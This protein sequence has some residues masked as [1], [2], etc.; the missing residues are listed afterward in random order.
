MEDLSEKEQLEAIRNWWQENGWYVIGGVVLGIV[1]L[2]GYNQWRGSAVQAEIDASTLYES[3][4]TGVAEGDI[5][6]AEAATTELGER[7]GATSYA[8][9]ARLA[10]ARLYMDNG[11]DQDAATVLNDLLA[12][13][14]SPEMQLIGRLRLAKVLL[15]QNRAQE[16]LDLLDGHDEGGF[17]ALFNEARGD[18]YAQLGDYDAARTAYTAALDDNPAARTVDSTLIQLKLNDLPDPAELADTSAAIDAAVAQPE[19]A[20]DADGPAAV[21][22]ES[23]Q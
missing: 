12:S 19:D 6:A 20:A 8:S 2:V 17:G 3:V 1:L 9:Q 11:R 18:A 23:E 22:D 21:E 13:G 15:Y 5:E 16:V 7:F 14:G 4:M 10:M